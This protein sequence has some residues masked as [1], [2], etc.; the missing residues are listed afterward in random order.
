MISADRKR[1]KHAALASD[2]RDRGASYAE[3]RRFG[4]CPR[5]PS[6]P[7]SRQAGLLHDPVTVG[8]RGIGHVGPYGCSVG[9]GRDYLT[10]AAR[11]G[12]IDIVKL[13]ARVSMV[14]Q[15]I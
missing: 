1:P 12:E 8:L 9:L 15:S 14:S 5:Y 10:H 7:C 11:R 3:G 13:Q 4:S 2:D 6:K